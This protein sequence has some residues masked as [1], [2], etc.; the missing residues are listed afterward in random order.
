MSRHIRNAA[1]RL[2]YASDETLM[3]I[4]ERDPSM[5]RDVAA[6]LL[7]TREQPQRVAFIGHELDA[8]GA[9]NRAEIVAEFGVSVP[10]ASADFSAYQR[11]FPSRM[12]Y[13]KTRK[14]YVAKEPNP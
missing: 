9:V 14:A 6:S 5:I 13:D 3:L 8:K 1:K 12:T 2:V 4:A 7:T 10:Q 11:L